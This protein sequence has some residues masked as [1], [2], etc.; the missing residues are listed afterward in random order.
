MYIEDNRIQTNTTFGELREGECFVAT[1]CNNEEVFCMKICLFD[2]CS[3]PCYYAIVLDGGRELV[4][5]NDTIIS[6]DTPVAKVNA[7]ITVW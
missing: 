6:K 1:D 7:Q 4:V 2:D 5:Y 3:N